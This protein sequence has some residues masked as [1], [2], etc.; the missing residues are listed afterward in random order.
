MFRLIVILAVAVIGVAGGAYGYDQQVKRTR[1]QE[2]FR[3]GISELE[4]TIASLEAERE[5]LLSKL[6]ESDEQ[7]AVLAEEIRILRSEL[8]RQQRLNKLT[9]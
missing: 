3:R 6:D 7:F 4:K 5:Q 2:R 9:S 1:D 8:A